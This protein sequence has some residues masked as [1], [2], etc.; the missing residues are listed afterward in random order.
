MGHQFTVISAAESLNSTTWT[1]EHRCT[2][3]GAPINLEETDRF[4]TCPFCR[5]KMCL[6]TTDCFRYYLSAPDMAMPGIFY[7]PYWRI[8]GM[9]FSCDGDYEVRQSLLDATHRASEDSLFPE[10]LGLRP[11]ALKLRFVTPETGA[12]FVKPSMAFD[13]AF[14]EIQAALPLYARA[15]QSTGSF[16]ST[17]VGEKV[18][19]VYAPFYVRERVVFDGIL[20]EPLHSIPPVKDFVPPRETA[21][22]DIKVLPALCPDCGADLDGGRESIGFFCTNCNSCWY[23]TG[24]NL[25]KV[26]FSV[27]PGVDS[28]PVHLPFWRIKVRFQGIALESFADLVRMANLPR[29]VKKE[30]ETQALFFYVPAFKVNAGLLLRIARMFTINQPQ[31]KTET[32]VPPALPYP[33]T[34][35]VHEAAESIKVI[36]ATLMA[37]KKKLWPTLKDVSIFPTESCLVYMPFRRQRQDLIHS[38]MQFSISVNSLKYGER[39]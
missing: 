27:M 8:K 31:D 4:F 6:T 33:I 12:N 35:P 9:T 28:D 19:L 26:P 39:L 11:Q 30:W 1:I 5:V 32:D 17:F 10:S 25:E 20:G 13:A 36:T 21:D 2:Q 38:S 22:G 3:C 7:V 34:F 18:S 16:Y 23:L 24:N 15:D 37:M 14:S 29:V